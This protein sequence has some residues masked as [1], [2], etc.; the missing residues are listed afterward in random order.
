VEKTIT[1]NMYYMA[2][3][4][5]RYV[6][7]GAFN[8][9]WHNPKTCEDIVASVLLVAAQ[10]KKWVNRS[11]S[12]AVYFFSKDYYFYDQLNSLLVVEPELFVN[13][14]TCGRFWGEIGEFDRNRREKRTLFNGL[15][16]GN[17]S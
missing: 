2:F 16:I 11:Y 15:F 8:M 4:M 3:T 13:L 17:S 5:Y 12:M 6:F 14:N 1:K 7:I 9:F 10:I